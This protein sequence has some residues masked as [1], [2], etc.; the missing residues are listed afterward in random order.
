MTVKRKEENCQLDNAV[1]FASFYVMI[2]T[3]RMMVTKSTPIVK[4]LQLKGVE[5]STQELVLR[6]TWVPV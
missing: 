6:R 5:A 1:G 3:F 2:S 4:A